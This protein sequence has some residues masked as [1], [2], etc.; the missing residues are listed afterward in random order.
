MESLCEI[1]K[2]LVPESCQDKYTNLAYN[3]YNVNGSL[4]TCAVHIWHNCKQQPF[5]KIN[6]LLGIHITLSKQP[7][8][9]FCYCYL[10]RGYLSLGQG[11]DLGLHPSVAS[12]GKDV[13]KLVHLREAI[14]WY[15]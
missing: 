3:I 7:L 13:Y 15:R 12:L 5:C 2:V 1:F 14:L 9:V 10:E 8:H 4:K 6:P 11:H